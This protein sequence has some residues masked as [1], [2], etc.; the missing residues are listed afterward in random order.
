[1]T[2]TLFL[3]ALIVFLT[4]QLTKAWIAE[5]LPKNKSLALLGA[6]Q[7]CYS[8]NPLERQCFTHR[9]VPLPLWWLAATL[10]LFALA[11]FGNF[12]HDPP[13]QLGLGA[14]LGGSG[15]NVYDWHKRGVVIDFVKLGWW[16]VFN[17]A[18]AAISLGAILALWFMR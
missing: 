18:D 17:L 11:Q 5:Y 7:F 6:L 4:D 12:F 9:R 14:A 10:G 2:V 16:P 15:S 1:M 8:E 13:A 3:A